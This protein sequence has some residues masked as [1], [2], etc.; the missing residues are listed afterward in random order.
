MKF[1]NLLRETSEEISDVQG[2]YVL[3]KRLKKTLKRAAQCQATG[4]VEEA[5]RLQLEFVTDLRNCI[6]EINDRFIE[7][8]EQR[9]IDMGNL[10]ESAAHAQT[11]TSCQQVIQRLADFQ[12]QILLFIHSSMLGLTALF[13]IL[14][15]YSKKTGSEMEEFQRER[16]AEMPI[17]R[18]EIMSST[19]KK[20]EILIER[21]TA[22]QVQLRSDAG[23]SS[24]PPGPPESPHE[25]SVNVPTLLSQV[26]VALYTWEQLRTT[27][28]TPST[29]MAVHLATF[30]IPSVSGS[31]SVSSHSSSVKSDSA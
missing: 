13:K 26:R 12:G 4:E 21:L 22:R 27:S 16:L 20:V 31:V 3:Y 10:E 6:R 2:L 23:E 19:V 25:Q 9:V 8:E 15:K 24:E 14:K 11:I 18:T 17:S 28:A 5:S 30:S 29:V 7:Q 1:C